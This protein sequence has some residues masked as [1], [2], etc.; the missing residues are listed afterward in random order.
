MM[1]RK[2]ACS[3]CGKPSNQL[4]SLIAGP[5]VFIAGPRV[6]ICD[7]CI[8]LCNEILAQNPPGATE[9]RSTVERPREHRRWWQRPLAWWL[10]EFYK[11]L[12]AHVIDH[13]HSAP[14]LSGHR[15]ASR[16]CGPATTCPA[17]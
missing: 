3:F 7:A 11:V 14:N 16:Q 13:D 5:R 6:M 1:R 4:L 2:L 9:A 8:A 15:E 17:S 12:W 10:N